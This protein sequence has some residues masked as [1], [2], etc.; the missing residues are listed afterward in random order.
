MCL[1]QKQTSHWRGYDK[2]IEKLFSIGICS[3]NEH[4]YTCIWMAKIKM[5]TAAKS[6]QS[7]PTLWDPTD[8]SP[9]G[10]S[11]RGILQA[12]T[13][14]WVAI[15]F[16]NAGKW[17]VK[18]K[19]LSRVQLLQPTRLLC[20]WDFPGKSTGV[21]CHHLLQ[22]MTT[23]NIKCWWGCRETGPAYIAGRITGPF[24]ES[25]TDGRASLWEPDRFL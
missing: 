5:T 13:L 14:E 9:P 23:P 17:K 16:S 10:S 15:S 18:V 20:L 24:C 21:G 12:R 19:L 7:C 8:G 6:L 2:L 3:E 4:Y 1:R 11:V 25:M 22:K